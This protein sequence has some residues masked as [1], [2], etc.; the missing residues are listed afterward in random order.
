L[1]QVTV[2]AGSVGS[3]FSVGVSIDEHLDGILRRFAAI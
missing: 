2:T 1:G 3:F